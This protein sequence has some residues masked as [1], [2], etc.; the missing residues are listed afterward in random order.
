MSDDQKMPE[1]T[2]IGQVVMAGCWDYVGNHVHVK[3]PHMAPNAQWVCE[4]N[5]KGWEGL[6]GPRPLTPVEVARHG[7]D[8][9]AGG[10][11]GPGLENASRDEIAEALYLVENGTWTSGTG[12]YPPYGTPWGTSR[13]ADLRE[14]YLRRADAFLLLSAQTNRPM[15]YQ[16][17][18]GPDFTPEPEMTGDGSGDPER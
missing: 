8:L 15:S 11:A 17:T 18:H 4:H 7:L 16:S 5:K 3:V 13:E 10:Q 12:R 9:V 1:P 14:E 2:Q 6:Y